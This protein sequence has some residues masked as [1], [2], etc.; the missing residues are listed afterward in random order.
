MDLCS[1]HTFLFLSHSTGTTSREVPRISTIRPLFTVQYCRRMDMHTRQ[2]SDMKRDRRP[3]TASPVV[4]R[5]HA[6][7]EWTS[8]AVTPGGCSGI[9]EGA[10]RSTARVYTYC[11]LYLPVNS[12]PVFV[13][14]RPRACSARLGETDV[15]VSIL[16]VRSNL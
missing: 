6:S 2:S 3:M 9:G 12:G 5:I 16:S 8:G 7:H 11:T 10:F 1:L 4:P 15:V 13:F 14:P